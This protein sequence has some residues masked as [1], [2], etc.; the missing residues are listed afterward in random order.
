MIWLDRLQR[1][2]RFHSFRIQASGVLVRVSI[3]ECWLS[4]I[5]QILKLI[6]KFLYPW[7][8]EWDERAIVLSSIRL[9]LSLVERAYK[10]LRMIQLFWGLLCIKVDPGCFDSVVWL[11]G[12]SSW[13]L[14]QEW[15]LELFFLLNGSKSLVLKVPCLLLLDLGSYRIFY[16]L[17]RAYW[18]WLFLILFLQGGEY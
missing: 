12:R 17:F 18:K 15:T 7:V 14:G 16:L 5:S 9:I 6:L 10:R 2:K 11:D 3:C 4:S 1:Y 8:S 13:S